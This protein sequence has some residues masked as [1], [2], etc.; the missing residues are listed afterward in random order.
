MTVFTRTLTRLLPVA[1]TLV[2]AACAPAPIFKAGPD[3][4]SVPPETVAQAPERYTGR[5]VIWGGQVVAV[6][7]LPGSTEIQILGYPLD[8]SQRPLPNSPIGG[9]FIAIMQGY[10]EPLNYPAGSLVTL[11]GHIE[12]VRTGSVGDA[13]YVFPLVKVTASHVWTAEELRSDKPHV[14][15]GVGIGIIRH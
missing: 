11:T 7:N 13:N 5:A 14:S 8:S 4:A 3:V 9:R 1:A 10:V 6:Q 15:F 2:L 12:G